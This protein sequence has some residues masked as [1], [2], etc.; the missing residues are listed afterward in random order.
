MEHGPFEDVS[1]TKNVD[2]PLLCF[3]CYVSLPEGIF[4]DYIQPERGPCIFKFSN[5][6]VQYRC[7]FVGNRLQNHQFQL[8]ITAPL[9]LMKLCW[10]FLMHAIPISWNIGNYP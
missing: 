1:P 7:F 10:M 6:A 9:R 8:V 4:D 2:I 3:H 5:E